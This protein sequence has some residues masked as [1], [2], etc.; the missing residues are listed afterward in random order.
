MN[1]YSLRIS[2]RN[3]GAVLIGTLFLILILSILLMGIGSYTSSHQS[4]EYIDSNYAEAMDI[5]EAG[6]N[7]EFSRISASV[8]N[9]DM[10]PGNT[11]SFGGGTIKVWC[12]ML[13]GTTAWDKSSNQLYVYS[14]GTINGVSRTIR[15]SVKGNFT[16]L[17]EDFGVY[18]VNNTTINNCIVNGNIGTNHQI[19]LNGGCTING[20][21][22]LDGPNASISQNGNSVPSVSYP[23]PIQWPTV[24]QIA[25]SMFGPNGLTYLA[26]NND[27]AMCSAINNNAISL[28]GSGVATFVGKPGGANY[29]LTGMTLKGSS[30]VIFDNSNG[31]INLWFGPP[32]SNENFTLTGGSSMVPMSTDPSKACRVYSAASQ[33]TLNGNSEL[34]AGIYAYDIDS[35]GNPVGGVTN[36]GTPTV[37]GA[38]IAYNVNLN[39]MALVNH[40]SGYFLGTIISN[41]YYG[42]NNSWTEIGGR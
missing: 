5:A 25:S 23:N 22:Y 9:A 7:W 36:S 34:D 21:A 15:A 12:T 38:V 37:N 6:T 3:N 40:Q 18:S 4:L 11:R 1:D 17:P 27:N 20:T 30:S 26:S 29:Y 28:T 39:G 13:D 41:G 24:S 16:T 19:G 14:Q 42:F 2:M 32:G 33:L 8:N 31:P 35:N 10:P